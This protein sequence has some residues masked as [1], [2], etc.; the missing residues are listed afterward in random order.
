MIPSIRRLSYDE[1]LK[2]LN[3]FP[4]TQR[5]LRGDLSLIQVFKIMKNIDNMDCDKYFIVDL[6]NYTRGHGY[7][8]VRKHVD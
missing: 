4:L 2:E 7:K 5:R 6:S 8:I 1:R 3:L